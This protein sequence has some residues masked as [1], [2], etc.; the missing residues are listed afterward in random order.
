M[1]TTILRHIH[2]A[3]GRVALPPYIDLT[4]PMLL[5]VS[6]TPR[7]FYP[8]LRRLIQLLK[9]KVLL[10]TG[11]LADSIKLDLFPSKIDLYI[12]ALNQ[13]RTELSDQH[14]P[15]LILCTGNH[16][17]YELIQKCFPDA[18]VIETTIELNIDGFA[19]GAG[20]Y[21]PEYPIDHL[22]FYFYGHM[23]DPASASFGKTTTVNGIEAIR[24]LDL[25]D[26]KLFEIPYPPYLKS[27]R[28]NRYKTGL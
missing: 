13:L 6:D 19:I 21:A 24:I 9:P 11:D 4:H 14:V 12:N 7:L 17:R 10:H 18:D 25:S 5:H 20:H 26:G 28:L 2:A 27:Y 8:E 22:D 15:R 1:L 23:P 3:L 16:D